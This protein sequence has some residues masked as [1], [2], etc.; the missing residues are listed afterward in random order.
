MALLAMSV[1]KVG[2]A[3]LPLTRSWRYSQ[4]ETPNLRQVFLRLAKVSLHLRPA[5]LRVLPLI[6]RL[7]TNSRMSCSLA[8][9]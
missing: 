3:F 1:P 9:L 8:L 7:V 4:K 6:L 5:S 2:M